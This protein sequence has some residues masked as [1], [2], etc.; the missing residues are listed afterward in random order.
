MLY[1]DVPTVDGNIHIWCPIGT[2]I[3]ASI[4]YESPIIRLKNCSLE[5]NGKLHLPLNKEL[6]QFPIE[7]TSFEVESFISDTIFDKVARH[8]Y[9]NFDLF[10][11]SSMNEMKHLITREMVGS[12]SYRPNA[13]T[14][15]Q[16]WACTLKRCIDCGT[17]SRIT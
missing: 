3:H 2:Y 11:T 9:N 13:Q 16:M 6:L 5:C 7:T 10:Q 17:A 14:S 1:M 15:W 12:T 8:L 4:A